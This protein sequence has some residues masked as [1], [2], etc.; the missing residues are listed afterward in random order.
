MDA[1][2]A[3]IEQRDFPELRGKPVVVGSADRRGVIAAASYEARKYG[4]R[5]AMPSTRAVQLCPQLI[6]VKHRFSAYREVSTQIR[7]IFHRYTDLVEPL[8]L[9]EA[10]LDVTHNK[11]G[12]ELATQIA[13]EIRDRIYAET[14]LTAS[15]GISFN[16][17]LA[18]MAS[19]INKP[20]GQKLIHPTQANA[21]MENLAIE[22]F[23]GVGIATATKMKKAGIDNGSDLKKYSK[24]ALT[25]LFGKQGA[26]FYSVVRGQDNREVKSERKR[27]SVGAERTMRDDVSGE[28]AMFSILA[29][30]ADEVSIRLINGKHQGKT[31]TLK[32]KYF[33]FEQHTRS[34]TL[35]YYTDDYEVIIDTAYDLLQTDLPEKPVRLLGITLSNLG[36]DEEMPEPDQLTIGF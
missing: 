14:Q 21:F 5:S 35:D 6:F 34:R 18:K 23:F 32:F 28:S 10:Y 9:D 19:D 26:Y 20:N 22:R 1:F 27:K 17:F 31:I 2:F 33:D 30:I 8:S 13:K 25:H 36:K 12:I 4:V 3:S 7:E 24:E 16:K 11:P 15:A 29:K